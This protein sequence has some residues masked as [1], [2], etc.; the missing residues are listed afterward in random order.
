MSRKPRHSTEKYDNRGQFTPRL[1]IGGVVLVVLLPTLATIWVDLT[2]GFASV[3]GFSKL[4]AMFVAL[5]FVLA[6]AFMVLGIE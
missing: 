3:P 1:M 4:G 2:N 6:V 5:M